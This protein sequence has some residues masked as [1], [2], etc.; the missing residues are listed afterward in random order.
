MVGPS[1]KSVARAAGVSVAS[2]SNAYN[3]PGQ[4]ST[5][6]RDRILAAAQ[7]QGYAGPDAAGRSLRSGRAGAIGVLL[8]ERLAYAFSDPYTVDLLAG[9][10][11]VAEATRTG[12]LLIPVSPTRDA[13][14]VAASVEVARQA[15][16]DG[17]VVYCVAADH[18]AVQV[19]RDRGVPVVA[20]TL[21]SV[22][23]D[24]FVF[25]DE[26][27]ATRQVA[28]L[29]RDLGHRRVGVVLD[30][31]RPAGE[32]AV[33]TGD[34]SEDG[35]GLYARL[36]L[37]GIRE[38]LGPDVE[39][40]VVTGGHNAVESGRAAATYLLDRPAPPTTLI[41]TSDIT[42]FGALDLLRDRG[43]VPGRDVSVTG[44]D[45]IP[46]AAAAGLTTVHQPIREKGRLM[47]RM[48]LDPTDTDTRVTLPTEL[49]VRTSTGPPP[50]G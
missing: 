28:S 40:T 29:V 22:R 12:L 10:A 16:V 9:I 23:D 20:S 19:M 41:A 48:L 17:V 34:D 36:R 24:M 18:P 37:Q 5:A 30:T 3:R 31:V 43:L 50:P 11:D 21:F 1:L 6:V 7:D 47:A 45:D 8:T 42:A 26:A 14:G 46:A 25:I 49:V 33:I 44:F 13:A 27:A 38:G 39:V 2:V 4:L 15:N 35:I 32:V